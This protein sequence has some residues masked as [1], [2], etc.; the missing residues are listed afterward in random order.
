ML[1][2][3]AIVALLACLGLVGGLAVASLSVRSY[4][5]T[6]VFVLPAHSNAAIPLAAVARNQ[7][8]DGIQVSVLSGNRLELTWHGSLD[9]ATKAWGE[10]ATQV[11]KA[12]D[13]MPGARIRAVFS[14]GH[15]LWGPQADAA[16]TASLGLLA[17][18]GVGLGLVVPFGS[19]L[20]RT[21]NA[22]LTR[23]MPAGHDHDHPAP[24]AT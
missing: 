14:S 22:S 13:G 11:R 15:A 4:V 7:H 9:A 24:G 2:R 17:G 10:V 19:R 21:R 1:R 6:E 5:A 16:R 23:D 8:V 12:T 20:I 3:L 18:L